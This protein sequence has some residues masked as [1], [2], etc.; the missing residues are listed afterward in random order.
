MFL[1]RMRRFSYAHACALCAGFS[2]T[3]KHVLIFLR[4]RAYFS[5]ESG[6]WGR[7]LSEAKLTAKTFS[8]QVVKLDDLSL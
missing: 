6:L 7:R 3:K 1:M 4:M 5:K 8:V 2:V